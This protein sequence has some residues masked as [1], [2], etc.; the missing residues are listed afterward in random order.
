MKLHA[1]DANVGGQRVRGFT[2]DRSGKMLKRL[3]E[4]ERLNRVVRPDDWHYYG[5]LRATADQGGIVV[6]ILQRVRKAGF[7]ITGMPDI[8]TKFYVFDLE[9]P[10]GDL[11]IYSIDPELVAFRKRRK[12]LELGTNGDQWVGGQEVLKGDV[13]ITSKAVAGRM[14]IKD[15]DSLITQDFYVAI[16]RESSGTQFL[17]RMI[18]PKLREKVREFGI[19]VV[20]MKLELT[21]GVA[22]TQTPVVTRAQE[23]DTVTVNKDLEG[24]EQLR[25]RLTK[26]QS[27][28]DPKER[29]FALERFLSDLFAIEGL[30]PRH[31]FKLSGEQIDGSFTW[32]DRT[33][34]L[35]AKWT[36]Q[37]AAGADFGAFTF[38]LDGKTA[39]TRGLFVSFNGFSD[40]ALSALK[41]KGNLRFV[42][43]DGSHLA[44]ALEP[45]GNL[46]KV[47]ELV[48]RH[49]D[50][51]GEPY[52]PMSG[53][54]FE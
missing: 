44:A 47:L 54:Y 28:S 42:C 24:R 30:Q 7:A 43:L 46:T 38:K 13:E 23:T 51:T 39:D 34:L 35:E 20:S 41:R 37:P 1:F 29:G 14:G 27:L 8:P 33:Y 53:L 17:E 25:L 40:D 16:V 52:L 2:R 6:E 49:A 48:W 15:Y 45:L 18:L 19:D 3:I 10:I 32:R 22:K 31:P 5:P 9:L 12:E 36:K 4:I 26:L 21:T 11:R 50:E